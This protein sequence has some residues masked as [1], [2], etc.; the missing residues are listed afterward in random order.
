V[1]L[2]SFQRLFVSLKCLLGV[3]LILFWF[4]FGLSYF[5][6]LSHLFFFWWGWAEF[7]WLVAI[8]LP[9]LLHVGLCG[10]HS[11]ARSPADDPFMPRYAM[12]WR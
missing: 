7:G 11:F 2:F 6:F 1:Y 12:Q 3:Y 4:Y 10:I 8:Y 5:F 9:Y